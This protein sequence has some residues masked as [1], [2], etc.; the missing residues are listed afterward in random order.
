MREII[1]NLWDFH[2][3]GRWVVVPT[4]G[5]VNRRGEAVMGRG[6][7]YQARM[8]YPGIVT[9]LGHLLKT[10]GNHVYPLTKYR[11]FSFPVKVHWYLM[12]DLRL[13]ALSCDELRKVFEVA[14]N[15]RGDHM[16]ET[17]LQ[18]DN[19]YIP[20]VGCGFGQLIWKDVF[21]ILSE[22]LSDDRFIAVSQSYIKDVVEYEDPVKGKT[23]KVARSRWEGESCEGSS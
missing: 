19:V 13:I 14:A 16:A 3:K 9:D 22:R 18:I 4:N 23:G 17:I 1:G 21:P 7:A 2:T 12:A 6:V 11:M 5:D 15:R 8:K 10:H 20:R